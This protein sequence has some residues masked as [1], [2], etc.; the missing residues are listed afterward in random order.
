MNKLTISHWIIT[1]SYLQQDL[2]QQNLKLQNVRS[3]EY[4]YI[5]IKQLLTL[6]IPRIISIYLWL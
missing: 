5:S 4:K 1:K 2:Q 3:E 6:R